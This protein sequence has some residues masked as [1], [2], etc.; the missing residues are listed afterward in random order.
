MRWEGDGNES[1]M[2][3]NERRN[4]MMMGMTGE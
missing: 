1:G 4:R 3:P 2:K